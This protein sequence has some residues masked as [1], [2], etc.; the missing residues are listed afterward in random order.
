MNIGCV[1]EIKNN[2]NRVGL[3]PQ[4]V[5]SYVK[6]GHRVLIEKGAGLGSGFKD[7][8][9]KK[10]G[11]IIVLDAADI[12]KKV[13]M[14]IKVKEPIKSEYK[15]F[16]KGLLIYTYLHLAANLPLVKALLKS[17]VNSVAYETIKDETGL[18]C[19]RP[20]SEV[21]GKLSILEGARFLYKSNHG[22]GLL[23]SG[24]TG[25]NPAKVLIIGGG[26]VGR[27]AL[28][29]AYGLGAE[30]TVLDI[31]PKTLETLKEKY[32]NIK[33]D[34]SNEENLIKHLSDS[35]IIVSGVL[36]P[37]A[38]AP[39]LIKKSYYRHMKKGAVIVDVAIDQGGSTESSH[40]TTHQEPVFTVNGIIHY[41]V[42]NMPGI[43]PKTSTIAL[44]HAT[45]KFGLELANKG[46]ECALKESIALKHGLNTYQGKLVI[47][48][49][50]DAF[51]L[52]HTI[53]EL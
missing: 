12:W 3:T 7:I 4:S 31:N 51:G 52:P 18:P 21:A 41:C 16:R 53:L 26:V 9:Y 22:V 32:P 28:S 25:V 17:G 19:L 30:V 29:Q 50:A 36:L 37:G 47:K 2:E 5:S 43:V 45:L 24:V 40:P 13:D 49:V 27:A 33:T 14:M 39:K 15:Y 1:K 34:V 10:A 38:K 8:D 11:A 46:L 42:A 35:E 48:E 20:M 23:I 6:A 44:N